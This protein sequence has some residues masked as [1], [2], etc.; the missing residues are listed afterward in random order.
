[1]TKA[2]WKLKL[3]E[4]IFEADTFAGKLFDIVLLI[5]ILISFFSVILESVKEIERNYATLLH[6]IEWGITIFF[7]LEYIAR[8]VCVKYPIRYVFSF[9]GIVDLISTLPTYLSLFLA[10]SH[11]LMVIRLIRLLRIFRIFKLAR[12]LKEAEILI[13]AI[14]ASRFKI[15]V[16]MLAILTFTAINGTIMYVIE[17]EKNGFT[18]IPVSMYWAIVTLT[19]VGYGDI[20]P[21][22][23][24]GQFISS[25]IMILGY[26]IIAVPTGIVSV[27]LSK[28]Q[29]KYTTQV[30]PACTKEGH[31]ADAIY[32]KF[33][34]EMLNP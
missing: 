10:G 29:K 7:T 16:F 2:N 6:V 1:M 30:C 8:V 20:A 22:T 33:C 15:I 26:A 3:Y 21:K 27:E 31:D 5:A 23:P 17:G 25:I 4:I 19:T 24:V 32:C 11:Y 12:Y 14:K 9:F 34:G 18:S 13:T 28:A